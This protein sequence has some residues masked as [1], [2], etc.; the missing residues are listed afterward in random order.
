MTDQTLTTGYSELDV[1]IGGVQPGD[2]IVWEVDSGVELQPFINQFLQPLLDSKLGYVSF[3]RSPQTTI[4]RIEAQT[5]GHR[6]MLVDCF[7]CGKGRNNSVFSDFYNNLSPE[8]KERFIVVKEPQNMSEVLT[9]MDGFE[10]KLARQGRYVFDSLTGMMELW[11]SEEEALIF[12]TFSCPR[13]FDLEAVAYWI[14]EKKAHSE[15]FLARIKHITQ[16]VVEVVVQD[17]KSFL[18]LQKA[19]NREHGPIGV[20]IPFSI[21]NGELRFGA[22]SSEQFSG[23][24]RNIVHLASNLVVL[25]KKHGLAQSVLARQIGVSPSAVCQIEKGKMIPSLDLV[26]KI[27]DCLEVTIDY[28]VSKP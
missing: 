21:K 25:R 13:L 22:G 9:I 27:A 19:E 18:I 12:F 26:L 3:N 1:L 23:Q 14:C 2:N 20:P 28:L 24:L 16:I 15:T 4:A 17:G 11:Q 5:Y 6:M 8:D 7:T 10:N